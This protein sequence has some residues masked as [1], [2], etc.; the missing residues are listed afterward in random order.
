[1]KKEKIAISLDKELLS[2]IDSK[3]D[4]EIIR[5]R[6][7]AIE[8]YLKRGLMESGISTVVL[9]LKGNHQDLP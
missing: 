6:S 7:Q 4:R 3:V 9:L 5:S 8:V 1:M 2:L